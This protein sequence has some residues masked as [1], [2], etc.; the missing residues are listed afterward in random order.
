[1]N[2]IEVLVIGS[3]IQMAFLSLGFFLDIIVFRD[4]SKTLLNDVKYYVFNS[5]VY[6]ELTYSVIYS[7]VGG[8]LASLWKL[9]WSSNVLGFNLYDMT[10]H[11]AVF[12]YAFLI[13]FIDFVYYWGHRFSHTVN[14]LWAGH[15]FHHTISN[16]HSVFV[17]LRLAPEL[18]FYLFPAFFPMLFGFSIEETVIGTI[19]VMGWD[20]WIH[21]GRVPKLNY[22]IERIFVTPSNHR[23]HHSNQIKYMDKNFGIM[24]IFWDLLFGTF[25]EEG[26]DVRIGLQGMR[27]RRLYISR[28]FTGYID[29]YEDF[30]A[31]KGLKSKCSVL[32][33]SPMKVYKLLKERAS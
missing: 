33:S 30:R 9:Y 16:F 8:S 19:F 2:F 3:S 21:S 14:I 15:K 12:K 17:A 4:K 20:F 32:F 11:E 28:Y 26:D 10:Q 13:L 22:L 1:M 7:V 29:L 25:A 6:T 23:V 18:A 5:K 24:F 27:Y 31:V